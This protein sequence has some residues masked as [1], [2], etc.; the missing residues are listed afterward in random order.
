MTTTRLIKYLPVLNLVVALL[1]CLDIYILPNRDVREIYSH[2][3][4]EISRYKISGSYHTHS[5]VSTSGTKYNI[6]EHP[7]IYIDDSSEF[8]ISKTALFR[9]H[10]SITFQHNKTWYRANLNYFKTKI[11]VQFISVLTIVLSIYN[12]KNNRSGQAR[13]NLL[14]VAIVFY[15]GLLMM[16]FMT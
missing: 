12:I 11:V 8:I 9:L 15:V 4:D 7:S 10:N 2:S 13:R 1:L 3:T 5:I 6:S 14:V 16:I